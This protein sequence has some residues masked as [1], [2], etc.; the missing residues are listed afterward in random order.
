MR[1]Q[2]SSARSISQNRRA[3]IV[4]LV[5]VLSSLIL[6]SCS[7]TGTCVGSGGDVLLSPVCKNDWAKSECKEWDTE[8]INDASWQYSGGKTCEGLG[9]TDTCS[10]G[11]Y[12][13][14][15]GC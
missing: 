10:D 6:S 3:S 12:R 5:I 8:E 2:K 1:L 11:S 15:G 7:S 9:Y 4:V 13:L 14:P